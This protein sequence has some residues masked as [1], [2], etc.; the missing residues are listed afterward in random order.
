MYA[1][2]TLAVLAILLL[3]LPLDP[4]PAIFL[5]G[6]L[7]IPGGVDGTTQLLGDRESTNLLRVITGLLLGVGVVLIVNGGLLFLLQSL[8]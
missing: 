1:S 6:I 3:G 4:Q 5:G 7:L 2:G 8:Y